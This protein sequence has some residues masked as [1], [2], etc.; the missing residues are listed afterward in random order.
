[1][2]VLS[3]QELNDLAKIYIVSNTPRYLYSNYREHYSLVEISKNTIES[4]IKYLTK[5]SEKPKKNI[6]DIVKGYA[7]LTSLAFKKEE[8]II[9]QLDE[10][11]LDFLKWGEIFKAFVG[12][13]TETFSTDNIICSRALYKL[14]RTNILKN[15]ST[16]KFIT[17]NQKTR[18]V[19]RES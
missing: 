7:F 11:N 8:D 2:K 9:K 17:I 1:M 16:D 14:Q 18:V 6:R 3:R 4:I 10:I 12:H 5:I 15:K 13:D 19:N